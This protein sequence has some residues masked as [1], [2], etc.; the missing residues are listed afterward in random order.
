MQ[1]S[2]GTH[3]PQ[4]RLTRPCP[5]HADNFFGKPE[6]DQPV[7]K[8]RVGTGSAGVIALRVPAPPQYAPPAICNIS[9]DG[10]IVATGGKDVETLLWDT[11]VGHIGAWPDAW[12]DASMSKDLAS[13]LH[14][15]SSE[16]YGTGYPRGAQS[17]HAQ[18]STLNWLSSLP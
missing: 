8:A 7:P 6:F 12:G 9:K 11:Q 15:S 18:T 13:W 16:A 2:C 17:A 4:K 3:S 5:I 14:G 1:V 10:R